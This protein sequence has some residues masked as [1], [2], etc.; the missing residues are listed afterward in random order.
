VWKLKGG[1]DGYWEERGKGAF[2]GVDDI[3]AG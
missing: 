1:K 2:T 3:L